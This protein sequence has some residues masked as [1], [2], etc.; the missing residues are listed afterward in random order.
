[1]AHDV[2][3]VHFDECNAGNSLQYAHR[4]HKAAFGSG[5]QVNLC[6]VAG[7]NHLGVPPHTCEKHLDLCGSGVLRFIEDYHGIVERPATHEGQRR[8]LYDVSSHILLQFGRKNHLFQCIIE[9][10]EIR[11]DLIFHIAGQKPEFFAGFHGRTRQDN[12]FYLLVFECP[13]GQSY[14]G[15]CF[16]RTG[17]TY[18][19]QHVAV[20][21]SLHQ[22]SLIF[23]A[24]RDGLSR[25]TVDD[26]IPRN[27]L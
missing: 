26:N 7:Y 10:L 15:V 4:F 12:L 24:R 11:I 5:R 14:G 6:A 21:V 13:N 27:I 2:L 18:G 25:G 9:G 16:S 3:F 20:V 19:K 8:N 17:R 23:G 22:S 1:M